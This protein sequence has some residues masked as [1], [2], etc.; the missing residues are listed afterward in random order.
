MC[1]LSWAQAVIFDLLEETL[2]P[3]ARQQ[4]E[5]SLTGNLSAEQLAAIVKQY[6]GEEAE[7]LVPQVE[8]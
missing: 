8:R 6:H 4:P 7:S 3:G 2:A 1:G 5:Q